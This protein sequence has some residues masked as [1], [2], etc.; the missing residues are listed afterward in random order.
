MMSFRMD[1]CPKSLPPFN[2]NGIINDGLLELWPYLHQTLFQLI[3]VTYALPVHTMLKAIPNSVVC[4]TQ[5]GAVRWPEVGRDESW[6]G[7]AEIVDSGTVSW[8]ADALSCWKTNRSP[9]NWWIDGSV[10]CDSRASRWY[11]M[12]ALTPDST[13]ISLVRPSLET[14][15]DTMAD[16]VKVRSR[17]PRQRHASWSL[18]VCQDSHV[19]SC[20]ALQLWI[21]FHQ[22][23]KW[24]EW[25]FLGIL[26][27]IF[28]CLLRSSVAVGIIKFPSFACL[29]TSELSS[30]SLSWQ[31]LQLLLCFINK[32]SK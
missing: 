11:A 3:D 14:A 2:G 28:L 13:K 15:T 12:S 23:R 17:D 8:W 7:L 30:A 9:A 10:C 20:Q 4:W 24:M 5:V 6:R 31:R 25:D 18:G 32:R 22:K 27:V 26:T 21:P 16:L 19:D 29:F 1:A